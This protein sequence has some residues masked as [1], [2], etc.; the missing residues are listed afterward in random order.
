MRSTIATV[1][2]FALNS[3]VLYVECPYRNR[4]HY[5]AARGS[6]FEDIPEINC[7]QRHLPKRLR[8]R[9]LRYRLQHAW[10]DPDAHELIRFPKPKRA[11]WCNDLLAPLED[12]APDF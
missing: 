11:V 1:D 4:H 12:D 10:G 7:E 2:A 6:P 5:H 9:T 3:K 8:G